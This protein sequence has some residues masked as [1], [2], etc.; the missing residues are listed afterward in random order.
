MSAFLDQLRSKWTAPAA[1]A[2]K[3]R[4]QYDESAPQAYAFFESTD[5]QMFYYPA[6]REAT[7]IDTR[8]LCYICDGKPGVWY[9]HNFAHAIHKTDNVICFIDKDLDDF[10]TIIP[11]LKG[12][13]LFVTEYYAVE[14]YVCTETA[15]RVLLREYILLPEDDP[16]IEEIVTEFRK[17]ASDFYAHIMP[18]MAWAIERRRAGEQVIFANIG[19]SLSKCFCFDGL[20]VKPLPQCHSIFRAECGHAVDASDAAIVSGVIDELQRREPKTW[21]RGKF[22]MWVFLNFVNTVWN[23]LRGYPIS[24]RKRVKKTI[25]LSADN[26]F[27]ILAGKVALPKGLLEFLGS[28]LGQPRRTT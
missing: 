28:N 24:V 23:N 14:N 10:L 25:H 19:G 13:R 16:K 6:I 7:G 3:F 11:P 1:V 15:V 26:I 20:D 21:V 17:C 22:E 2:H 8:I 27:S 12:D 18:L 4:M 5:D 9:A